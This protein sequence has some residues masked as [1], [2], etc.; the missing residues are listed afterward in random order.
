MSQYYDKNSVV[1]T[2]KFLGMPSDFNSRKK[3]YEREYGGNYTGTAAQNIKMNKDLQ[4]RYYKKD[5][6]DFDDSNDSDD[7]DDFDDYDDDY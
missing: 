5:F 4:K 6:D 1:D 7:N 3:R 2:M